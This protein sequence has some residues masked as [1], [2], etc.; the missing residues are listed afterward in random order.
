MTTLY[1]R[2]GIRP[3]VNA[4]GTYTYLSGCRM[5]PETVEAMAEAAR[6]FVDI[7]E[8][9]DAAGRRLADLTGAEAALVTGGCAAALSQTAAACMAGTDPDRIKQLPDHT[10]MRHEIY[11]Q[12]AHRNQYDQAFRMAGATLVEFDTL[13][14][15]ADRIG[16]DS[17]AVTHIIAYEPWGKAKIDEVIDFCRERR[18][19]VLVDAAAELPPAENLTRFVRMGADAVM[20]SGGKGLRGPQ[21]SGLLLGKKWLVEAARLNACPNHSVGR[22]MKAGKEEIAGLLRAVELYVERDHAADWKRWQHQVAYVADALADL[23]HVSTGS[24]PEHVI[25]HVPRIWIKWDEEAL[26]LDIDG[27]LARLIEGEPRVAM[28]VTEC[29]LTMSPNSLEP[30][31]EAIVAR[32]LREVL[33][34][35]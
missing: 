12:R 4:K 13:D 21:A 19:P 31:E 5:L 2:L 29:G 26:P 1:G 28:L 20:F 9:E 15:L 32:R 35:R 33:E 18:L 11:I 25:N 23:P 22:P 7:N 30:G 8:L 16:P 24:V 27:V 6:A 10:G 14:E 17:C 3:I 34:G